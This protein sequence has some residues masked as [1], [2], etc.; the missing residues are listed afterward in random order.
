MSSQNEIEYITPTDAQIAA[1]RRRN[2]AIGGALLGFTAFIFIL[3]IVKFGGPSDKA[4]AEGAAKLSAPTA[5][6]NEGAN[7]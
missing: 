2:Y 4:A 6:T 7:E 5:L 3:M 1:R